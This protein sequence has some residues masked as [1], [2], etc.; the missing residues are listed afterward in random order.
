MFDLIE[1]K[2]IDI[3][4]ISD[5]KEYVNDL[6]SSILRMDTIMEFEKVVRYWQFVK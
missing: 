3:R 4:S 2:K 6:E 5:L 1:S